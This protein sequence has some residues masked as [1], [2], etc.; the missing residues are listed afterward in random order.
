MT[1]AFDDLMLIFI[2]YATADAFDLVPGHSYF[3]LSRG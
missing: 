2:E 3:L 1:Q